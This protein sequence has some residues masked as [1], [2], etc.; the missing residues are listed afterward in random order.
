MPINLTFN[1]N[2]CGMTQCKGQC[3][4]DDSLQEAKGSQPISDF[5][6]KGGCG[7]ANMTCFDKHFFPNC[8]FLLYI[9]H[10]LGLFPNSLFLPE[11]E[12]NMI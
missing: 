12:Q 1:M 7:L 9:L 8:F 2:S 6:F 10:K 3:I 5:F 11:A 4:F